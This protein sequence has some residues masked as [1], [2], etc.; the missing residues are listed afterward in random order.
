MTIDELNKTLKINNKILNCFGWNLICNSS[1][2]TIIMQSKSNEIFISQTYNGEVLEFILEKGPTKKNIKISYSN[3]NVEIRYSINTGTVL[4]DI[5]LI[6]DKK[7]GEII[8]VCLKYGKKELNSC[9]MQTCSF[10]QI[11]SETEEKTEVSF[12]NQM[13]LKKLIINQKSFARDKFYPYAHAYSEFSNEGSYDYV[14]IDVIEKQGL[15]VKT[16]AT[17]KDSLTESLTT[18]SN[19]KE[20]IEGLLATDWAKAMFFDLCQFV[21][22]ETPNLIGALCSL[23]PQFKDLCYLIN[24]SQPNESFTELN[25]LL[26]GK[27]S[28]SPKDRQFI[29]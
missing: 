28:L 27:A 29:L 7:T 6:F 5:C 23:S 25:D 1:L 2:D 16:H 10:F 22:E 13:H 26:L 20:Y 8:S 3:Q 15:L 14:D 11:K 9:L 12:K 24:N 17:K 4:A 21:E 18:V 19:L